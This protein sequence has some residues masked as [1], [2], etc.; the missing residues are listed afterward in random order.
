L[1]EAPTKKV[2][3]EQRY[4]FTALAQRRYVDPDDVQT[5]IEILPETT[6]RDVGSEVAIRGG[7]HPNVNLDR[8][9][10]AK[11]LELTL[12]QN[13]Q[14]LSLKRK[15]QLADFIEEDESTIGDFEFA[16]LL[17]DRP[18]EGSAFVAE[19]FALEEPSARAA[20]FMAT[21]GRRARVLLRCTARAAN[22]FPVPVSPVMSTV[23]SARATRCMVSYTC[24]MTLLSPTIVCERWS[25]VC[26]RSAS[27]SNL[28]T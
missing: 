27:R 17:R 4:V 14:E 6:R 28:A 1:R 9:R 23:V 24:C 12:L 8:P 19:Q 2:L 15:R 13:A 26:N 5:E 3:A 10:P 16:F 25:S 18:S 22:S 7:D 21:N 20:Q 11:P